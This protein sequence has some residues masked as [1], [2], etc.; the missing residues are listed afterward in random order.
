[1][2][3]LCTQKHVQQEKNQY[4]VT[5]KVSIRKYSKIPSHILKAS[6]RL[7]KPFHS[8]LSATSLQ[9]YLHQNCAKMHL[10]LLFQSKLSEVYMFIVVY[11]YFSLICLLPED[12]NSENLIP[13]S[14]VKA[15]LN[16]ASAWIYTFKS[17]PRAPNK[18]NNASDTHVCTNTQA[19]V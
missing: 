7:C 13:H 4:F 2:R 3:Q 1:M 14:G 11:S 17:I 10:F 12:D 18:Y 5:D 19:S 16:S 9:E 8:V 6:F 15:H